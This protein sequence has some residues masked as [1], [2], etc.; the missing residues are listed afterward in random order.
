MTPN[1]RQA[2]TKVA[3]YAD[4]EVDVLRIQIKKHLLRCADCTARHQNT[5][6]L[7]DR[8]RTEVPYF[9]SS[10]AL[11]ARVPALVGAVRASMPRLRRARRALGGAPPPT[12]LH[13]V[14]RLY[15]LG[16]GVK[17]MQWPCGLISPSTSLHVPKAFAVLPGMN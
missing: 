7:R 11:R 14:V 16:L 5:L 2:E 10:P 4:G 9:V 17:A 3:A 12:E 1:G 15:F 6:A 13:A 8:I